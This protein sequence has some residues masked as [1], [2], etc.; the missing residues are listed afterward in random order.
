MLHNF[1]RYLRHLPIVLKKLAVLHDHSVFLDEATP[2]QLNLSL[3]SWRIFK[4]GQGYLRSLIADKCVDAR[5]DPIPWYTYPAIEQLSKWDFSK[6]DVLEYGCGNSTLWWMARSNSVT[7]IESSRE[8]REYVIGQIGDNAEIILSP[9]GVDSKDHEQITDYIERV[10]QLGQFD[11]IVID[12]VNKPGVRNACAERSLDHL[13]PGGLFIVDNSDWLP[14]TCSMMR[15]AAFIE[16]DYSGLGP[17]NSHAETTT[18][19]FKPDFAI[20]AINKEHPGYSIGGLQRNCDRG[21]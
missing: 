6:C 17:L 9:V 11:V 15:N 14:E 21:E 3:R 12:G 16:V 20:R 4:R 1:A 5:G 10:D 18:L 13:K 19:F 8:W 7:S 2:E